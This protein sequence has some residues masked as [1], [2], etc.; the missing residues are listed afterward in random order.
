M[1]DLIKNII[2]RA[3]EMNS[4]NNGLWNSSICSYRAW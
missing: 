2:N 4:K 1:E 3:K